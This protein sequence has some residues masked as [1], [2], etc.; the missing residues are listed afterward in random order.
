MRFFR[1]FF[2]LKLNESAT[3][4]CLTFTIRAMLLEPPAESVTY[5]SDF[6]SFH[7]P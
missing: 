7:D 1:D 4:P 2:A 5:G 6:L 3:I